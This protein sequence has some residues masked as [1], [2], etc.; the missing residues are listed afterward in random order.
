[1]TTN[2]SRSFSLIPIRPRFTSRLLSKRS[3]SLPEDI[4]TVATRGHYY[5]GATVL[6]PDHP[7][8]RWINGEKT[9]EKNG[10]YLYNYRGYSVNSSSYSILY[11]WGLRPLA[12]LTM[13]L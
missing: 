11:S 12:C 8:G 2:R 6:N 9:P 1:M 4:S 3:G 10:E 7:E 13:F 5:G